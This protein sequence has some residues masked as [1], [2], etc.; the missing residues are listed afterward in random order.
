MN[1]KQNIY[2][3]LVYFIITFLIYRCVFGVF[4]LGLNLPMYAIFLLLF[5]SYYLFNTLDFRVDFKFKDFLYN[6]ILNLVA[7]SV[8]YFFNKNMSFYSAFL[9]YTCIQNILSYILHRYR[10][11]K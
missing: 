2:Y 11:K 8:F 6:T 7:F 10:R 9:I 5:F 4:K 1:H 3:I